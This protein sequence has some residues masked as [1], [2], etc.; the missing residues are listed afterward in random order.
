M[1]A[2]VTEKTN[3]Q[4]EWLAATTAAAATISDGRA[5]QE[6]KRKFTGHFPRLALEVGYNSSRLEQFRAW[7]VNLLVSLGVGVVRGLPLAPEPRL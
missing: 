3:T 5:N 7:H 2:K 1:A 6:S 4:S